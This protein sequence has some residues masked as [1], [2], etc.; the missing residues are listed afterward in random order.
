VRGENLCDDSFKYAMTT[1]VEQIAPRSSSSVTPAPWSGL[2]KRCFDMS[3]LR[4]A[5][6]RLLKLLL[7]DMPSESRPQSP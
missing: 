4:L 5:P 1:I 3:S 6:S 7:P 2:S